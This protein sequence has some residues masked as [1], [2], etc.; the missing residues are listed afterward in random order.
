MRLFVTASNHDNGLPIRIRV[1]SIEVVYCSSLAIA[2]NMKLFAASCVRRS[3][4]TIFEDI[5][6]KN[7]NRSLLT[8][9]V[10]N[11]GVCSSAIRDTREPQRY[12]V[13]KLAGRSSGILQ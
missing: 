11:D 6:I 5:R 2:T 9:P 13:I 4:K 10:L 8:K 7:I 3:S 12:C 1:R